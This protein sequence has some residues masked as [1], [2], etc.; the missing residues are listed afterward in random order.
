MQRRI[1]FAVAVWALRLAALSTLVLWFVPTWEYEATDTRERTYF[2]RGWPA[3]NRWLVS[4]VV[5]EV[6]SMTIS[7]DDPRLR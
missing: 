2:A 6:P 5:L 4:E 3:R 7:L 1:G